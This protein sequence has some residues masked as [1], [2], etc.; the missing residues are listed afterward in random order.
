MIVSLVVKGDNVNWPKSCTCCNGDAHT[1][2]HLERTFK[3][4]DLHA[5]LETIYTVKSAQEVPICEPCL[6]HAEAS[7]RLDMRIFGYS[8]LVFLMLACY[9]Y[10]AFSDRALITG[11]FGLSA[12]DIWI[13]NIIAVV[14]ALVA[15]IFIAVIMAPQ[16]Q[17]DLS[18]N[19]SHPDGGVL[20]TG[21]VCRT[22]V[23]PSIDAPYHT[24]TFRNDLYREKFELA[25]T[26]RCSRKSE[27]DDWENLQ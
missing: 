4:S 17:D 20:Y 25:N 26:G 24:F 23:S 21:F 10:F 9:F 22:P 27:P 11:I 5:P 18:P 1:T 7:L 14:L 6:A 15:I 13:F 12:R 8:A 2:R 19:C 3:D 16:S